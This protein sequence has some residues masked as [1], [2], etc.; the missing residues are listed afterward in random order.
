MEDNKKLFLVVTRESYLNSA[1]IDSVDNP[2]NPQ[3]YGEKIEEH[4]GGWFVKYDSP[5]TYEE[6]K[7][8]HTTRSL[9]EVDEQQLPFFLQMIDGINYNGVEGCTT[10]IYA[11]KVKWSDFDLEEEIGFNEGDITL[12]HCQVW[13]NG[14]IYEVN[15]NKRRDICS[16]N[17]W[18]VWKEFEISENEIHALLKE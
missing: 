13:Y 18:E 17:E 11:Y 14:A 2:H 9:I 3:Y 7:E 5:F 10:Y 16:L 4:S 15:H 12:E 1:W 8:N 6:I